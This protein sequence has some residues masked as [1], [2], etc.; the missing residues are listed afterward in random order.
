MIDRTWSIVLDRSPH[1]HDDRCR[2]SYPKMSLGPKRANPNEPDSFLERSLQARLAKIWNSI[3]RSAVNRPLA[4]DPA[5]VEEHLD[6]LCREFIFNLPA[7]FDIHNPNKEWDLHR[8]MLVRQ[9]QMLRI[10]VFTLMCQIYRPVLLLSSAQ[11]D[12]MA[13]YKRCLISRHRTT[14]ANAA[15]SLLDSIAQ[16]HSDM[17]G[18]Q[19]KYFLI[20]FYTFEPAMLLIMY[21]LSSE[22]ISKS[23][24]QSQTIY[25]RHPV[26]GALNVLEDKT[27]SNPNA[28]SH[29]QC[30]AEIYRARLRLN[31][32]REV[33]PIAE[34]GGHKIHQ[35][36]DRLV[37]LNA[38]I[39]PEQ[40]EP[41]RSTPSDTTLHAQSKIG[42]GSEKQ[43]PVGEVGASM[44]YAND[45]LPNFLQDD[46]VN[47]EL[48]LTWNETATSATQQLFTESSL[49]CLFSESLQWP[50]TEPFFSGPG[51]PASEGITSADNSK[52]KYPTT[53]PPTIAL[54]D[55]NT[56]RSSIPLFTIPSPFLGTA[57]EMSQSSIS[58][59]ST[60][61][62]YDYPGNAEG[63]HKNPENDLDLI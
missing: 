39:D 35:M 40:G 45:A 32:L 6:R 33:S 58:T 38:K 22:K 48:R 14:L 27:F 54:P 19:T 8:P 61:R 15:I 57:S 42:M 23:L 7:V 63:L 37:L 30:L 36:V 50:T 2:V 20:S 26:L 10:S 53:A 41:E 1:I 28:P 60:R 59:T 34:L 29:S 43:Q 24:S 18:N 16:L 47:D 11:I 55:T 9:R 62:N 13:Y 5:A 25:D 52:L 49:D 17:G 4:Y 44:I 21:L 31:T 12:S 46:W 56:T 3:P 51:P